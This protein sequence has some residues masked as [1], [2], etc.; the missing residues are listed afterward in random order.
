MHSRKG[1]DG[2]IGK[3]AKLSTDYPVRRR[4][5]ASGGRPE[6]SMNQA[7]HASTTRSISTRISIGSRAAW[8]VVRAGGF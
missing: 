5:A 1:A 8:I 4:A 2:L 3:T 6:N 7:R